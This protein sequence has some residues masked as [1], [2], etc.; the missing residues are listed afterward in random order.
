VLSKKNLQATKE[1]V[2]KPKAK[3]DPNA[4]KKA[5]SAYLLFA[6]DNRARI[7]EENPSATFGEIGKY[8]GAE[9]KEASEA[10]KQ[11]YAAL[12]EKDKQR[13]AAAMKKYEEKGD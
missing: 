3:K 4:P 8:L 9:W 12:Q 2:S 7:K 5:V 6:N 10:V 11:K 1:K 13:Y